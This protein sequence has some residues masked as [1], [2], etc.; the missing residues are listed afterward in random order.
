MTK[1]LFPS[2]HSNHQNPVLSPS[3]KRL[4]KKAL[5]HPRDTGSSRTPQT[6]EFFDPTDQSSYLPS[7]VLSKVYI[8]DYQHVFYQS[9][10]IDQLVKAESDL[11]RGHRSLKRRVSPQSPSGSSS[12]LVACSIPTVVICYQPLTSLPFFSVSFPCLPS[13]LLL[14][15]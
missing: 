5:L 14:L 8:Q 10:A 3:S 1:R 15:G 2:P 11:S 7:D 6:E 13:S 9:G 4:I 12:F